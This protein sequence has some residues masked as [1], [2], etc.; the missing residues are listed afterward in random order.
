MNELDAIIEQIRKE[1]KIPSKITN[2]EILNSL[3]GMLF[4]CEVEL[5]IAL[6]EFKK[7]AIKINSKVKFQVCQE[8]PGRPIQW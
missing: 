8:I 6:S 7:E 4:R 5:D 2:K 1:F 3:D